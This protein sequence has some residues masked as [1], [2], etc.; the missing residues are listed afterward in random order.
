V[1]ESEN[2]GGRHKG[3]PYLHTK[4]GKEK[5]IWELSKKTKTTK[6]NKNPTTFAGNRK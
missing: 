5:K 6:R 2:A 3:R 1:E 4:L